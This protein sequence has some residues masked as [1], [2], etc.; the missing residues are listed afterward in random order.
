MINKRQIKIFLIVLI[1]IFFIAAMLFILQSSRKFSSG[2]IV[3]SL[4]LKSNKIYTVKEAADLLLKN[5]ESLKNV[6]ILL[7]AYNVDGVM[8]TGCDDYVVKTDKE[9]AENY[10][11]M[12]NNKL[13]QE[14]REEYKN[15][16]VLLTGETL[17]LPPDSSVYA[18]YQGHFFDKWATGSCGKDGYRRFVIE[19]K[20]EEIDPNK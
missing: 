11:N 15:I 18:V 4:P 20:I 14:Q 19:K 6:S 2:G 17:T 12:H 10:K 3:H 16:A 5:P 13:S 1:P 9:N 8:G 7:K